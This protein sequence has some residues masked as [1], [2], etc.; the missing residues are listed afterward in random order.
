MSANRLR[1]QADVERL[2]AL[3]AASRGRLTLIEAAPTGGAPI[4]FE[5]RCRTAVSNEYPAR[6]AERVLMRVNLPARYPFERPTVTIESPIFHPN[7]FPSGVV[8][9]GE[10]W[11]ASE[12]LDLL[13]RRM[14]RLATFDPAHVNPASAANRSAASWYTAQIA[15]TP[16]A[17][18][19]DQVV[20]DDARTEPT[21]PSADAVRRVV[22]HCPHC[23]KALRLPAGRSGTVACPGC[24]G[25]FEITT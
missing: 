23:A 14:I 19:T 22:R 21:T 24:R 8:C 25:E 11:I 9:Q 17:F 12:S 1:R 6:A 2:R 10:R 7:V 15:R 4:R 3:A 5:V 13:V 18:P 16:S 20:F